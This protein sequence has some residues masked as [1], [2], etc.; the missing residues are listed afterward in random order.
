VIGRLAHWM[1]HHQAMATLLI[2]GAVTLPAF[3]RAEQLIGDADTKATEAEQQPSSDITRAVEVYCDAHDEC[4]H[5]TAAEPAVAVTVYCNAHDECRG[6]RA[7]P[8]TTPPTTPPATTPMPGTS[9]PATSPPATVT[10]AQIAAAVA[11]FCGTRNDCAG[12]NG[13]DGTNGTN[14][15]DG[16]NGINGTNGANG[17]N[18]LPGPACPAGY[19]LRQ[20]RIPSESNR[21]I[22]LICAR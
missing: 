13:T 2:V 3:A 1:A 11:A 22:F 8:G 9:P 10:D 18:G 15:I 7:K 16:T 17:A 21:T 4:S 12:A 19:S 20:V 5:V 14:G 6:T